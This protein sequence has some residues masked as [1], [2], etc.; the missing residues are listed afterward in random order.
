M[1]NPR[2]K[3]QDPEMEPHLSPISGK[4]KWNLLFELEKKESRKLKSLQED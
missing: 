3:C 4:R 1:V 2:L